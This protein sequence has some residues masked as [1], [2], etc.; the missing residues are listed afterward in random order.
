MNTDLK[1][2]YIEYYSSLALILS[3]FI[4]ATIYHFI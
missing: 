2:A 4:A 1:Q 3:P